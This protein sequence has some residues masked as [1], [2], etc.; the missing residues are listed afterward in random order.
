MMEIIVILS[1][2]CVTM[3]PGCAPFLSNEKHIL[4]FELVSFVFASFTLYELIATKKTNAIRAYSLVALMGLII[5]AILTSTVFLEAP[6]L[7]KILSTLLNKRFLGYLNFVFFIGL[8]ELIISKPNYTVSLSINKKPLSP[9]FL[10]CAFAAVVIVFSFIF[11]GRLTYIPP[12]FACLLFAMY[13]LASSSLRKTENFFA[14]N[15]AEAIILFGLFAAAFIPRAFFAPHVI[16]HT[17]FHG[18]SAVSNIFLFTSQVDM[19]KYGHGYFSF[20]HPFTRFF[21]TTDTTVF[22]VNIIIGSFCA[23]LVYLLVKSVNGRKGAAGMAGLIMAL[24]PAHV[25][26]SATESMFILVSFLELITLLA[27]V[28][29][30]KTNSTSLLFSTVLFSAS[31]IQVRPLQIFFPIILVLYFLLSGNSSVRN[32]R[33]LL[34]AGILY[35]LI[36]FPTIYN[37]YSNYFLQTGSVRPG[38]YTSDPL[39]LASMAFGAKT[40]ALGISRNVF[41]EPTVTHPIFSI[42]FIA[43]VV[44]LLLK[45]KKTLA[46]FLF[47]GAMFAFLYSP[48]FQNTFNA[49]RFHTGYMH[50]F[51]VIAGFGAAWA[52]TSLQRV[53]K[54][55][56]GS[57]I[58]IITLI[59]FFS[60][61]R[62]SFVATLSSP[63]LEYQFLANAIPSLP[64]D[65]VIVHQDQFIDGTNVVSEFPEY[66]SQFNQKNHVWTNFSD[67]IS[68]NESESKEKCVV[69]YI[70]A[71]CYLFRREGDIQVEGNKRVQCVE[72]LNRRKN[73][74][75]FEA[76][77]P[78]LEDFSQVFRTREPITMGFYE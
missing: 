22:F 3:A 66:L 15:I 54:T 70:G 38:A 27:F 46:M 69:F 74:A 24:L 77:I 50:Y 18:Y 76:Q 64:D 29:Y 61:S 45:D 16:A 36:S 12:V 20:F 37:T 47:P 5:L 57:T 59:V 41:F 32:Y 60:I 72:M 13:L 34:L 52:E 4:N 55:P 33:A 28:E 10:R 51:V 7:R 1:L 26:Y 2:L 42:F 71:S 44:N 35:L 39:A 25:K 8:F 56:V 21:A 49:A 68:M 30:L 62:F 9:E 75:L 63:Q 14:N 17:N 73:E 6:D 78:V 23:P 43:G 19:G 58:L 31:L 11:Q 48:V 65:C 40:H 53:T 67:Y